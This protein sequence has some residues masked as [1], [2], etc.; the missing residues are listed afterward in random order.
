MVQRNVVEHLVHVEQQ[1]NNTEWGQA[2][3]ASACR[4]R[5][6]DPRSSQSIANETHISWRAYASA[7]WAVQRLLGVALLELNLGL[8][9]RLLLCGARHHGKRWLVGT[10]VRQVAD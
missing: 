4:L 1:E 7:S 6:D 8:S 3:L 2:D 5:L 10:H 9:D